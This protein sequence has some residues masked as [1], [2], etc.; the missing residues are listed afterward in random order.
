MRSTDLAGKIKAQTTRLLLHLHRWLSRRLFTIEQVPTDLEY[1]DIVRL[2]VLP[3]SADAFVVLAINP[4]AGA[5]AACPVGYDAN[6]IVHVWALRDVERLPY[7]EDEL[8][9]ARQ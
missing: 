9:P 8:L 5:I 4:D 7:T 3:N 1:G 6:D 2:K